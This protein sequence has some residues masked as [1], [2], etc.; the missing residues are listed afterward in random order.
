MFALRL[1]GASLHHK[2]FKFLNELPSHLTFT[3]HGFK[4][5]EESARLVSWPSLTRWAGTSQV[6]QVFQRGPV[7]HLILHSP[8]LREFHS[9][10]TISVRDADA[11]HQWNASVNLLPRWLAPNMVTLLGFL[12]ILANIGLLQLFMPDLVGPV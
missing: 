10:K 4:Q 3:K 8:S 5:V 12:F 1:A 7:A 6:L 11:D 2:I 9:V